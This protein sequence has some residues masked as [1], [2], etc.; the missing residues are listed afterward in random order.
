MPLDKKQE[1]TLSKLWGTGREIAIRDTEHSLADS[2]F[3]TL[4]VK[5]GYE[6]Q[7]EHFAAIMT[8]L[9]Q[10]DNFERLEQ[11]NTDS[12]NQYDYADIQVEAQW[13]R[14]PD[15]ARSL[16]DMQKF[17]A[18]GS[19]IYHEG[20][21]GDA[22]PCP[23][24]EVVSA[25]TAAL[26]DTCVT[27]LLANPASGVTA[28]SPWLLVHISKK[29]VKPPQPP[30]AGTGDPSD[31]FSCDPNCGA[32]SDPPLID[33]GNPPPGTT[34]PP[35]GGNPP[36]PPNS[37]DGVRIPFDCDVNIIHQTI[38]TNHTHA[39]ID[40]GYSEQATWFF[41]VGLGGLAPVN[42][43][44]SLNIG[45][46]QAVLNSAAAYVASHNITQNYEIGRVVLCVSYQRMKRI[47]LLLSGEETFL[48]INFDNQ[49][50]NPFTGYTDPKPRLRVQR[51]ATG[52]DLVVRGSLKR[53][54]Q[55]GWNL[56]GFKLQVLADVEIA[57][58][59][60]VD[61]EN[62]QQVTGV[63]WNVIA[64]PA[65]FN[66]WDAN[67]NEPII[68]IGLETIDIFFKT[69]SWTG[70]WDF[71]QILANVHE[72]PQNAGEVLYW[73]DNP[74]G[75]V[76][77]RAVAYPV[78]KL[79]TAPNNITGNRDWIHI[80]NGNDN[81]YDGYT[82]MGSATGYPAVTDGAYTTATLTMNYASGAIPASLQVNTH[83][84][85]PGTSFNFDLIDTGLNPLA[86][87]PTNQT[88]TH[89]FNIDISSLGLLAGDSLAYIILRGDIF[90]TDYTL[91]LH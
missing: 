52:K 47:A 81:T 84:G 42:S 9:Y 26:L 53:L 62:C 54:G 39:L 55:Y 51:G 20:D 49:T 22:V 33:P 34:P 77:G 19:V 65:A 11:A 79:G 88:Q 38:G 35:P 10:L 91:R 28:E 14:V 3:Y 70:H 4:L 59:V 40:F 36:D 76:S 68:S 69:S 67:A 75:L 90:L 74:D 89:V 32:P 43:R 87:I 13:L 80:K 72:N 66:F 45:I 8:A 37:T 61:I 57:D 50:G 1:R 82:I 60:H 17:V 18:G 78:E 30:G 48:T 12:N 64:V 16:I 41:T 27:E 7:A 25:E 56:Q 31:P 21:G 71:D 63:A 5:H 44:D 15:F 6:G 46:W 85:G 2:S 86:P 23:S 58:H 29:K 24:I 83:V 73:S